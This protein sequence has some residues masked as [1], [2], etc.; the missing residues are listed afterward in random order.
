MTKGFLCKVSET[1]AN[2]NSKSG[3]KT[4]DPTDKEKT[5]PEFLHVYTDY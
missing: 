3:Q 1:G 2:K 5:A 4:C